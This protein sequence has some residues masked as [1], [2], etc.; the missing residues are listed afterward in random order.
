MR[1]VELLKKTWSDIYNPELDPSEVVEQ[2]F[3]VEYEQCIN[4]VSMRRADYVDHVIAQRN[5]MSVIKIIYKHM[6]ESGNEV[7][8]VYYQRA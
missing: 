5:S 3:H 4:G 6:M 1:Y 2:Y 7:F 8:G